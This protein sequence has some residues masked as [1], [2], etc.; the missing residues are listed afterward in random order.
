[1]IYNNITA[2]AG[3]PGVRSQAWDI[4]AKNAKCT[5]KDWK[6]KIKVGNSRGADWDIYMR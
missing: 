5:K 6:S 2:M 4:L 3:V 1:V